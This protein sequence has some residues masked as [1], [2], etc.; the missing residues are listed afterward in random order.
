MA[1]KKAFKKPVIK[2][3]V[4]KK[5]A[6]KTGKVFKKKAFKAVPKWA[7]FG[8]GVGLG[9]LGGGAAGTAGIAA[10]SGAVPLAFPAG[11]GAALVGPPVVSAI[12]GVLG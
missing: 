6:F 10:A 3:K 7:P 4:A 1:G 12:S 9:A 8:A 5:K 11:T 2:A